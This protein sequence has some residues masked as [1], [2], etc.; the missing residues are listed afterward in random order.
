M[1]GSGGYDETIP[2][3]EDLKFYEE[4]HLGAAL[5]NLGQFSLI[6]PNSATGPCS[7]WIN[8]DSARRPSASARRG[9]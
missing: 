3:A 9:V 8:L 2:S 6:Y 4:H 5:V 1:N 7:T